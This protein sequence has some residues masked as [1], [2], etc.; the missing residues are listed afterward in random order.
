[1][2]NM[3]QVPEVIATFLNIPDFIG[4]MIITIVVTLGI[5]F[6]IST[7]SESEAFLV[8]GCLAS[9]SFFTFIEWFPI[10]LT[11]FIALAVAVSFGKQFVS[12]K[13]D[14]GGL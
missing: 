10:W 8:L 6:A 11:I 12:N 1:M 4:G 13:S 14:S 7:L 2:V 5:G 9:L 3:T